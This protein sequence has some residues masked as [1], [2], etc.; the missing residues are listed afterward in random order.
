M[1]QR[2][3]SLVAKN[4]YKIN[5]DAPSGGNTKDNRTSNVL[6]RW[7]HPYLFYTGFLLQ[8]FYPSGIFLR[9]NLLFFDAFNLF[10]FFNPI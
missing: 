9:D 10:N 3:K 1:P 2:G 4:R 8:G 7:G 6:P 5:T